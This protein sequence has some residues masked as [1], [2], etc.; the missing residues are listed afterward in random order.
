MAFKISI[1]GSS[2]IR[3][4]NEAI[5]GGNDEA[6]EQN[7]NLDAV[8]SVNYVCRG[9]WKVKSVLEHMDS[10]K[11][12]TPDVIVQIGSNRHIRL[13]ATFCDRKIV[14]QHLHLTGHLVVFCHRRKATGSNLGRS[15]S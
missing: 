2:F 13:V 10:I 5:I 1:V 8:G 7:F 3:R 4:L 6:F 11:R 14:M 15:R 9:G 12:Q